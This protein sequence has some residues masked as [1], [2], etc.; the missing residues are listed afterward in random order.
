MSL[1]IEP[2][3]R[4]GQVDPEHVKFIAAKGEAE[5]KTME[6]KRVQLILLN[7]VNHTAMVEVLPEMK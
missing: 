4:G 5:D 7:H 3:R 6:S 1:E 2:N